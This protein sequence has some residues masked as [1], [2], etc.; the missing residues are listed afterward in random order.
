[1]TYRDGAPRSERFSVPRRS[2]ASEPIR[3]Q[4]AISIR[5]SAEELSRLWQDPHKLSRIL[6]DFAE[7][8]ASASDT[9]EWRL[10]GPLHQDLRFKTRWVENRA[11]E[12]VS[13]ESLPGE[14]LQMRGS[15]RFSSAP[16]DWGTVVMLKLELEPP[17]G[18]LGRAVAELFGSLPQKLLQKALRRFKSLAETGEIPSTDHN[19]AARNGGHD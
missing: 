11:S 12:L 8:T 15:L 2:K 7:V 6:G 18:N 9:L 3:I 4:Q 19:P 17:A 5:R 13:W 16:N 1:V 10:Q 14:S